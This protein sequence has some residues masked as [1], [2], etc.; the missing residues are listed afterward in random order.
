MQFFYQN[1]QILIYLFQ[2]L[3]NLIRI[4]SIKCFIILIR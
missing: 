3:V 1:L 2:L 4:Y